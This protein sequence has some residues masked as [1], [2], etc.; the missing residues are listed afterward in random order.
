[1]IKNQKVAYFYAILS[2]L[3]WSTVASAF[4]IALKFVS[5]FTLLFYASLTATLILL[6]AFIFKK[7][8]CVSEFR[9]HLKYS[10]LLGFINPFIY[11]MIL[12]TAY[13]LLPAQIAQPLNYTWP[14][15]LSLFA[16]FFL[17]QNFSL[18]L[19]FSIL[20]SFFGVIIIS[21]TKGDFKAYSFSY[22]G[23]FL[24]LLSS[25]VWAVYWILNM[26]RNL[27]PI[28]SLFLNFLFG[29]IYSF[30]F[31]LIDHVSFVIPNFKALLSLVYVGTFEMGLTFLFWFNA[32]NYSD[33]TSKIS[34]LIYLSPFISLIFIHYIVG[35]K[36]M[37]G[38]IYGLALIILGIFMQ[39][40]N[41]KRSAHEK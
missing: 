36:I 1:M 38:T 33:N 22:F 39:S 35:E 31:L 2:I 30:F 25:F 6:I 34:N 5:P 18:K 8:K 4:K 19:L 37:I 13:D 24:A 9:F 26:K 28:E 14:I 23:I 10:A 15:V 21:M 12:F 41:F 16:I 11:Y 3:G 7:Q 20:L 29:T 27:D 40:I 32:L 17:K